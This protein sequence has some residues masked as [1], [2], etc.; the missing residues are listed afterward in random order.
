LNFPTDLKRRQIVYFDRQEASLARESNCAYEVNLR[1]I[2]HDNPIW[3]AKMLDKIR[4]ELAIADKKDI[5]I[6][7]SSNA[8]NFLEMRDPR[9]LIA[10]LDLFD[11]DEDT[12]KSMIST[13]PLKMIIRNRKKLSREFVLPGVR[14]IDNAG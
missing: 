13:T 4:R 9:A 1:D 12:A 6:I 5:P 8:K 10:I 7:F 3:N 11:I 14:R 2:F